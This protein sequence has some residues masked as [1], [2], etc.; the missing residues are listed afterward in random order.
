MTEPGSA[1]VSGDRPPPLLRLAQGLSRLSGWRRHGLAMLL[2]AAA[3]GAF[4]PFYLVPLLVPAFTGLLWLLDGVRRPREAVSLGWSFGF[5]HMAT[6]LSWI[7]LAFLVD[8][9]RFGALMPV[10][11]G[12]MA[13]G[14]ALFPAASILA[15]WYLGQRGPARV[16]ALAGIWLFVEWLRSWILTGF[17][18]NLAG[19]VWS[20]SPEAMQAAALGGVWLRSFVTGMAAA[21]PAVLG[22]NP[23]TKAAR[24]GA[25]VFCAAALGLPLAIWAGGAWRLA[26]A[27]APGEATVEDVRLRIV[28]ASIAQDL[29]WEPGLRQE[30]IVQQLR[31]TLTRGFQDITHVVWPETAV[32][33]LL[34][35]DPELRRFIARAVPPGGA[36]VTGAPRGTS[37]R[38]WN[39]LI[40]LD[41]RGEIRALYDKHHLVPFGEYVPFRSVLPLGKLTA[42]RMDFS[43]GPGPLAFDLPGAPAASPLICYEVIFPGRVVPDGAR[44]SWLLNV[45]NDAWF[46][47]SLGPYQHLATARMR[48][49]EEGLP[50]VRAANTGISAVFDGYGREI[51]RLALNEVGVL[52]AALPRPLE[53]MTWY[54]RLGNWS[55]AYLIICAMLGTL[56]LRRLSQ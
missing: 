6:G 4:A 10:A 8:A 54:A 15:L 24:R 48:A 31:L 44:P 52:D 16:V 32:T 38:I 7:G 43:A 3:T 5:G 56:L 13:A 37:A 1:A 42:G 17:P 12:T 18:W 45:T 46:G 11:V 36:L 25:R 35:N 41:S 55:V 21:A 51:G 47:T 39:S 53:R 34:D 27:P 26:Q 40:A 28:Q 49:V 33:F 14:M 22:T 29:K 50:L 30:H 9:E 2:G 20:F 23:G 19:Y